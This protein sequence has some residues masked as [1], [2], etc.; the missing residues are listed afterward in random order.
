M[1]ATIDSKTTET[2]I[3]VVKLVWNNVDFPNTILMVSMAML[4]LVLVSWHRDNTAFDFRKALLDP[5]TSAISFSRLGHFVALIV[6]TAVLLHQTARGTLTDWLFLGYM[7][8][9]ATVFAVSKNIDYKK[10]AADK[11][12]GSAVEADT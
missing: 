2:A 11:A 5:A 7:T 8:A 10:A 4:V 12:S 1:V 3:D 6:S 9:W